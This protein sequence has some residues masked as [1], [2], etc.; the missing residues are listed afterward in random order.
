MED[1]L[2]EEDD[3]ET[4]EEQETQAD[5][6]QEN[7]PLVSHIQFQSKTFQNFFF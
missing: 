6:A 5:E 7:Q 2:N 3:E 4:H 1:A